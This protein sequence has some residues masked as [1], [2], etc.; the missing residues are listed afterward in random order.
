MSPPSAFAKAPTQ[1][2]ESC[3]TVEPPAKR[4]RP[5]DVQAERMASEGNL[6]KVCWNYA[7]GHCA[8]GD[9]CR[10]G[11]IVPPGYQGPSAGEQQKWR[12]GM[13][14]PAYSVVPPPNSPGGGMGFAGSPTPEEAPETYSNEPVTAGGRIRIV[15]LS[16]RPAF[17]NRIAVCKT[18]DALASRWEVQLEDGSILRVQEKNMRVIQEEGRVD[19]A[20][21][22]L[23]VGERVRITGLTARPQLNNRAALCQSYDRTSLQWWVLLDDGSKL[24]VPEDNLFPY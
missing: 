14:N 3:T 1:A 15:G 16:A 23:S 7:R 19:G 17:N 18:Y 21:G 5:Q 6:E 24:A 11:H 13:P 2:Y 9:A 22:S 10:W 8:K 4:Q 20:G 12:P